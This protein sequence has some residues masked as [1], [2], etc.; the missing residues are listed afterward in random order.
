MARTTSNDPVKPV[1][2]RGCAG[3]FIIGLLVAM[4]LLAAIFTALR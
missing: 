3:G 4:L 1:I 2:P